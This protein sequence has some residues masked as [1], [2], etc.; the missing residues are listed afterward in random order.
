MNADREESISLEESFKLRYSAPQK[1]F[2]STKF[3]TSK[4]KLIKDND[5]NDKKGPFFLLAKNRVAIVIKVNNKK[6]L[7]FSFI[8][9]QNPC[10]FL[11][12]VAH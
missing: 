12:Q 3:N 9:L 1:I 2:L 11:I 4:I 10:Y 8:V 5:K 6:I 7:L